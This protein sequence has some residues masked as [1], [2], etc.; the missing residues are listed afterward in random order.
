ME[1]SRWKTLC[2]V[3]LAPLGV[4]II[5]GLVVEMFKPT[6]REQPP[7]PDPI[8]KATPSGPGR[9]SAPSGSGGRSVPAA[10]RDAYTVIT[11]KSKWEGTVDRAEFAMDVTEVTGTT[12]TGKL[13]WLSKTLNGNKLLMT[14]RMSGQITGPQEVRFGWSSDGIEY[15]S[16]ARPATHVGTLYFDSGAEIRGTWTFKTGTGSGSFRLWLQ[17]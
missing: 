14:A 3:I 9:D 15:G 2:L 11:A 8:S 17:D 12:F 10:K 5:G 1:G 7:P 6:A 16:G 4:T 13:H